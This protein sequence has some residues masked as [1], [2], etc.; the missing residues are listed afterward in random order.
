MIHQL[1]EVLVHDVEHEPVI[2]LGLAQLEQQALPQIS[3]ANPGWIEAL[4]DLQDLLH[5]LHREQRLLVEP[6]FPR[7]VT[8]EEVVERF[9]D[10]LQRAG[11]EAGVVDIPDDLFSD[12]HLPQLE[13]L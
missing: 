10:L 9:D 5:F 8:V 1:V 11:Q 6:G 12:H 7:L 13:P 2:E 3:C 4:Y